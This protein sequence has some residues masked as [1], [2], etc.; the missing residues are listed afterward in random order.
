MTMNSGTGLPSAEEGRRLI[1]QPLL[2]GEGLTLPGGL[3]FH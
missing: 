3:N 2:I 1:R